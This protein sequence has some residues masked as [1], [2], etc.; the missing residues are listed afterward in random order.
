MTAAI[1]IVCIVFL[2]PLF[3][4]ALRE[5]AFVLV[6]YLLVVLI[7]QTVAIYV[8]LLS[9]PIIEHTDA[10]KFHEVAETLVIHHVEDAHF[11]SQ[12]LAVFYKL[13][14]A[15]SFLGSQLSIL[16]F[17]FS[18]I[19]FLKLMLYTFLKLISHK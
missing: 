5:S 14:G 13:F 10:I 6:T 1:L 18:C 9:M 12:F 3:S 2:L 4:T 7:H 16:A 8:D 15:S 11:Y 17:S 19:V